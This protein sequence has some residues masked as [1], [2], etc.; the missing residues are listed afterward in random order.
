MITPLKSL[1]TFLF[2]PQATRVLGL[3]RIIFGIIVIYTFLLWAKD[4]GIFF[5]DAGILR[6][7]TLFAVMNRD[8]HTIFRWITSPLGVKLALVF[9]FLIAFSF[10]I[11]FKTRLSSILLFILVTS[12]HERN[13]LVLNSADTVM[14]CMLFFFMFAPAGKS[15]SIDSLLAR[16]KLS[17]NQSYDSFA[18]LWPQRMMQLQ[19]A[20]IYFIT[21]YAKSRGHL[22]HGGEAM[23][24]VWGLVNLHVHGV[25]QLMNFPLFYST[26]TFI[27]LFAELTLPYLLWFKSSRPYAVLLGIGLHLWI[28]FFMTIPV[29]SILMISTYLVFFT[30]E[31]LESVLNKIKNRF[32]GKVGRIYYDGNCPLCLRSKKVLTSLDL[33]QRLVWINVRLEHPPEVPRENS[34]QLL[35]EMHLIT[36]KAEVLSGFKA[37]RWTLA[38]LPATFWLA[39]FFYLPG[40]AVVGSRLY[41]FVADNRII[42]VSCDNVGECEIHTHP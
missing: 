5:S 40:M 27:T 11:G 20:T 30:D 15:F 2:K 28:M 17:D 42:E 13:N 9:L 35:Q 37:F 7:N 34:G 12:F 36:P 38:Y 22:W 6:A 3:Y 29:F 41:R 8:Y 1:D 21:A 18:P 32:K 23:Y 24:Y 4:I 10:T 31:E 14:R 33:F 39:P 26:M 19:V 25:E 16:L